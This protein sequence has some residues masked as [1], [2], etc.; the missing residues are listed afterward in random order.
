M[1]FPTVSAPQQAAVMV[2]RLVIPDEGGDAEQK[3]EDNAPDLAPDGEVDVP[4][5]VCYRL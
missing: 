4:Y 2:K 1:T 3:E 5:E